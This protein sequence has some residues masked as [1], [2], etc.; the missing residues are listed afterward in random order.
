VPPELYLALK[1]LHVLAAF[2]LVTGIVGRAV[3]FRRAARATSIEP[4]AA[5][6]GASHW[7]DQR[8]VI[9]SFF[10]VLVSGLLTGWIGGVPW[11]VN[12]RPTWMLAALILLLLQTPLIPTVLVPRRRQREAALREAVAA[13]RITPEL[14]ATLDDRGVLRVRAVEAALIAAIVV[15]M[16]LKS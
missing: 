13:G 4:A 8:L 10:G 6:L 2:G 16:V 14:R 12:G 9:P 11:T 3:S 1:L 15:L 5:L 7:F